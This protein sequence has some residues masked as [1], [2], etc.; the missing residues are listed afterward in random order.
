MSVRVWALVIT[1]RDMQTSGAAAGGSG[2]N[3]RKM[4]KRYQETI[5][6]ET[7]RKHSKQDTTT[8]HQR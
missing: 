5:E 2:E 8:G 7:K 4:R 3:W 6:Q 1:V